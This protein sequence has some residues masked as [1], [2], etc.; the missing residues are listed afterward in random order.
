MSLADDIFNLLDPKN[1][2][3]SV[4]ES[5]TGG[6][7]SH[8]L[9]KFPGSSKLFLGGITAY[10]N[11]TKEKVLSISPSALIKEGAV[12]EEV[13]RQMAENCARLFSSTWC[14]STTGISGPTG[15]SKDKPVGLVWIG[16]YGPKILVSQQFIFDEVSRLTHREKTVEQALLLLKNYLS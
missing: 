2:T 10:T 9:T 5:C 13:A 12:S 6:Y 4:A 3:L 11:P 1:Q 16:L 14:L 15:G 7:L 8:E